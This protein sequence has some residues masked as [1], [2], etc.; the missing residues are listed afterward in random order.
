MADFLLVP[1]SVRAQLKVNIPGSCEEVNNNVV[2]Y[3]TLRSFKQ[4][5]C[6][7][8]FFLKAI[9]KESV[10]VK[11]TTLPETVLSA[12]SRGA[13]HEEMKEGLL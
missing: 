1:G 3:L 13:D 11:Q 5:F 10:G 12:V 4:G 6:F 2:F 8:F 9:N 7:L